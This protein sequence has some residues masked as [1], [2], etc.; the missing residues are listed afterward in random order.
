[1]VNEQKR[2]ERLAILIEKIIPNCASYRYRP[3]LQWLFNPKIVVLCPQ[4][5][6]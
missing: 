5:K 2:N 1:M 3:L 4:Q 6:Q